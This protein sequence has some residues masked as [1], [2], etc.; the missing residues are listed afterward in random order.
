[1]HLYGSVEL[2]KSLLPLY[3]KVPHYSLN[4]SFPL[5]QSS[6]DEFKD[7]SRIKLVADISRQT[8]GDL[9]IGYLSFA[10]L[11]SG[12]MWSALFKLK[13]AGIVNTKTET[14]SNRYQN[15]GGFS[16]DK[17]GIVRYVKLAQHA[18][19]MVPYEEA[20]VTIL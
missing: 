1:M 10:A 19:D 6:G 4:Y 3:F 14:G 8:Y 20:V 7:K 5:S 11:F 9:G 16:V 17:N 12:K 2:G 18:G 15:S 13:E